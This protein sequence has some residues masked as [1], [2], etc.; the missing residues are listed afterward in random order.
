MQRDDVSYLLRIVEQIHMLIESASPKL[1]TH[2]DAWIRDVAQ[3]G[4]VA[5]KG[6]AEETIS[7][8]Y[9]SLDSKPPRIVWCQSPKEMLRWYCEEAAE[10]K[11]EFEMHLRKRLNELRTSHEYVR[12]ST[13]RKTY[14]LIDWDAESVEFRRCANACT[15]PFAVTRL[16]LRELNDDTAKVA[17]SVVYP[18][19]ELPWLARYS[20]FRPYI[21]EE[22]PPELRDELDAWIALAMG[23]SGAIFTHSTCFVCEKP[24]TVELDPQGRCHNGQGPVIAWPDG[25]SIFALRN[26]VFDRAVIEDP[27]Y[28]NPKV[29]FEEQNMLR[30]RILIE[31]YTIER[32]FEEGNVKIIDQSEFGT[33]RVI[34]IPD[35]ELIVS[36]RVK[37]STPEPDGTFS[38][39]ELRVPPTMRTAREAVAWSFDL[40]EDKYNPSVQT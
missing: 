40:Q 37:N 5:N 22:Y 18:A 3:G 10:A 16:A 35:D 39:Y 33:L 14:E 21:F 27:N 28:L 29:I 12:T 17:A 20:L 34:G 25:F 2:F 11:S 19:W 8:I 31:H 7:R 38:Y 26:L 36:V 23:G 13:A 32:L 4:P 1:D 9:E 24:V 6:F 30:R 15:A